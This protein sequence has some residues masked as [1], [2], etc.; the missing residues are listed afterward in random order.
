[1]LLLAIAIVLFYALYSLL[2]WTGVKHW[3][4]KRLGLVRGY[5]LT[6][7]IVP[8]MLLHWVWKTYEAVPHTAF[9]SMTMDHRSWWSA[10]DGRCCA[11]AVRPS[12]GCGLRRY[13]SEVPALWPHWQR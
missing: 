4:A 12:W 3:A 7:S 5:R 2:A 13:R 9:W 11:L 10:H 1:M 6:Y 8:V